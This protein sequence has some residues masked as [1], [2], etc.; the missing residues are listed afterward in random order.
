MRLTDA[1]SGQGYVELQGHTGVVFELDWSDTLLATGA[2]DGTAR[3][4]EVTD[5]GVVETASVAAREGAVG[6]LALSPDGSQLLTGDLGVTVARIWEVGMAGGAEWAN[7][8]TSTQERPA[9]AFADHGNEVVLTGEGRSAVLWDLETTTPRHDLGADLADAWEI[10]LSPDGDMVATIGFDNPPRVHVWDRDSAREVFTVAE[11]DFWPNSV[12]WGPGNLLAVAS[13][14]GRIKVVDRDGRELAELGEEDGLWPHDLA[15]GP[16]GRRLASVRLAAGANDPSI[17]GIRVW[18]WD[19][20]EV[21]ASLPV[22][23]DYLAFD[24]TGTRIAT[25]DVGAGGS[26]WDADTEARLARMVGHNGDINDVAFSPDGDTV[27][28]AGADGTVRLWSAASGTEQLVLRG[29]DGPVWSVDFSPD[30][31]RLVSA[32]FGMARVWALD[33]D[34]LVAIAQTRLTRALTDVECQ[35]YLHV[36]TCPSA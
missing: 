36:E 33:L 15:F 24:S 26:I 18:D 21:V 28:T 31:D 10:E 2:R 9:V 7:L 25:A 4:W 30:G 5:G 29:H 8:P 3:V 35:Q 14:D 34:D 6:G 20:G 1:E 13:D 22:H 23:A 19:R 32:G 11:V 16:D 12:A 27:A 17:E